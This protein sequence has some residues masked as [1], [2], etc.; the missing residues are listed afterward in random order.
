VSEEERK[1]TSFLGTTL[2]NESF[3]SM[4]RSRHG[5][6]DSMDFLAVPKNVEKHND[7]IEGQPWEILLEL[8]GDTTRPKAFQIHGDVVIGSNNQ[9]DP[10]LDVNLV[11]WQ[12]YNRGVSRRH[13]MM[14]PSRNKLFL[15]DLRST[16]GTHVNGLPL[17]VGWAYALQDGDLITLAQLHLRYRLYR[18]P[19]DYEE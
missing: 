17:G 10:D 3:L 11:E 6:G 1:S 12:G 4:P 5:F 14:R 18:A 8:V 16:N 9:E 13:A 15:L 19:W 7:R 2:D